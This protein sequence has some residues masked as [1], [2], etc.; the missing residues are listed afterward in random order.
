MSTPSQQ[1]M[2]DD[3]VEAIETTLGI[4]RVKFSMSNLS[5]HPAPKEQR[6][7]PL[8]E[9]LANVISFH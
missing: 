3:F 7:I 4:K 5:G 1:R 8:K 9:Y 2:F 6:S